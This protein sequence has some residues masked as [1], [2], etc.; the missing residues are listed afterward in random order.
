M[1]HLY[2]GILNVL[3]FFFITDLFSP[4]ITIGNG[5]FYEK[6]IYSVVFAVLM[7]VAPHILLF[8]KVSLTEV[9]EFII[10][11]VLAS[12]FFFLGFYIFGFI[13]ISSAFFDSKVPIMQPINFGDK[14]VALIV[15]GSLAAAISIGVQM[16]GKKRKKSYSSS[17]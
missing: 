1:K 3:I 5:T 10:Q 9:S 12:L 11:A 17:Y 14:S 4:I 2:T 7:Y 13:E 8:V 6:F 16:L 15:I